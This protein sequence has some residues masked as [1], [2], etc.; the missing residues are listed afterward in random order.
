MWSRAIRRRCPVCGQGH[1]FHR[2]FWMVERCPRCGLQFERAEGTWSG[3]VGLN[4]IVTFA[5]LFFVMISVFLATYPDVSTRTLAVS[6][7]AVAV[8]C[9]FAFFPLSRTVWLSIDLAL[10]PLEP[11]ETG[12]QD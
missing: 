7:G 4:M 8:I 2:W 11:G 1:L 6:A 9:P 5:L 12:R 10:R 3:S